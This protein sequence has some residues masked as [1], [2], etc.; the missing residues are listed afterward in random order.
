M[1]YWG[2]S[3]QKQITMSNSLSSQ[4]SCTGKQVNEAQSINQLDKIKPDYNN[5]SQV[6]NINGNF[7][8]LDRIELMSEMDRLTKLEKIRK[9]ASYLSLVLIILIPFVHPLLNPFPNQ[10][11]KFL[12]ISLSLMGSTYL[13]EFLVKLE[14]NKISCKLKKNTESIVKG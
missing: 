11:N 2:L 5:S 13:I 4:E 3:F 1:L 9:I 7:P 10:E 14:I 6:S 8:E 12:T